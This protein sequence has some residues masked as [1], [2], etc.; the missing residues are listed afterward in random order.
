MLLLAMAGCCLLQAK[1]RVVDR[2]SFI[3]RNSSIIE[4]DKVV[5]SDTATVLDVKAFFRPRN[6]IRISGE[7]YLLGDD[8]KKYPIRSGNGIA[9]DKNFWMPDNGEAS[10]SLVFPALPAA[11]KAFDFIESDCDDCFKVW[12]IALDGKLPA[13]ALPAEAEQEAVADDALPEAKLEDGKAMLCGTVLDYKKHYQLGMKVL[14]CDFLTGMD[15]ETPLEIGEDGTFRTEIALHAPTC[16]RLAVGKE[17]MYKLFLVPGQETKV[18]VNLREISRSKSKLLKE[19]KPEGRQLYFAGAMAR[20]NGELN[21]RWS[22]VWR[23][24]DFRKEVYNMTAEQYKAYCLDKY[25]AMEASIRNDKELDGAS[26]QFLLA[27]NK[28]EC[29]ASLNGI[30]TYLM[31]AFVEYGGLPAREAY[32]KFKAPEITPSYYDYVAALN[33]P[34]M[35]YCDGYSRTMRYLNDEVRVKPEGDMKDVF[36]YILASDKV[37]AEDAVIIK[38]YKDSVDAGKTAR[39]MADK[40]QELRRKYNGLFV[41]YSKKL[42]DNAMEMLAGYM[43]TG[44]GLFFDLQ[45]AMQYAQKVA[46][47]KLLADADFQEI[48]G[49]KEPYYLHKLTEMNDKLKATIEA[50]KRKS[51]FTVNETGEVADKDLFYSMVSKFKGKVVL[52]DFWATWCGPCKMAMK[53]MKPMKED[54]AGKD[55]V[56]LFVAGENSPKE[57][58]ENMIPDI[59]GEHYRV[60]N[61]QWAYLSKEFSIQGVPTYLI[62]DKEGGIKQKYTGFPG[63]DTVKA[64]LLKLLE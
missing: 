8:G 27:N 39:S 17:S 55:I 7:S 33:V 38:E 26:R 49:I 34:E 45:K 63:A 13:L 2:P 5:A 23:D 54:L 20:L 11:V 51:G 1:E 16:V 31:N 44:Q 52:V 64:E 61:A 42:E 22:V 6:W 12:G 14:N 19:N 30:E 50:N 59:H 28:Y 10:F 24:D 36:S 29:M 47:F 37:A 57:T 43:G 18:V 48:A 46:D 56:Y 4:I 15:N 40:M 53:L 3:A 58:W 25:N 35:L 60:T 62:L 9:L 41:E 32:R 21:G